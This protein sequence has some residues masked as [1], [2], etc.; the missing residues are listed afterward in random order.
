[1]VRPNLLQT[2]NKSIVKKSGLDEWFEKL[3]GIS[4]VNCYTPAPDTPRTLSCLYTGKRPAENGCE[5]RLQW[6]Y[7]YL[8]KNNKTIFD[9][10]SD[11]DYGMY[12][13]ADQSRIDLGMF[14]SNLSKDAKVLNN[15]DDLNKYKN[16]I[17]SK[18]NSFM[19]VDFPDYHYAVND[20][21]GLNYSHNLGVEKLSNSFE[22]F[23]S[24]I[25]YTNFDHIF[26]FS[27]HGF[28]M[29]GDKNYFDLTYLPSD[30]RSKVLMFHHKKH[31]KNIETVEDLTS[32]LDI[33]PTLRE[34]VNLEDCK[35]D[36]ISLLRTKKNRVLTVE[37]HCKFGVNLGII[38]EIWAVRTKD[39]FY[40]ESIE[41]KVLLKVKSPHIYTRVKI[42][43]E[44]LSSFQKILS[45]DT[46]SYGRIKEQLEILER[47][48][49]MRSL[50]VLYSDRSSRLNYF[51]KLL[52]RIYSNII[53]LLYLIIIKIQ[54]FKYMKRKL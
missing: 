18:K 53:K 12:L 25:P 27:D 38:H 36:G 50:C 45:K 22:I 5:T 3:G 26:I 47:Y 7:Y 46:S 11:L 16:D 42:N 1:M 44:L 19:F 2:F 24:I 8:K 34:T 31:D 32:I 54:R 4:F 17:S 49:S 52:N 6:P 20:Y 43:L 13:I 9:I 15:L 28:K 21:Y 23:F 30:N 14:P 10:F 37:D 48:K 29:V 41:S 40:F 51:G 35:T 33:Y 39:Y